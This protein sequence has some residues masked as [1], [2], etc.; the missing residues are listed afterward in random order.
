VE[1]IQKEAR[2]IGEEIGEQKGMEKGIEKRNKEIAKEMKKKGEPV[3]KISEYTGLS[4]REIE[5]L[6]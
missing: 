1:R 5:Q 6:K 4:K 3:E 2:R